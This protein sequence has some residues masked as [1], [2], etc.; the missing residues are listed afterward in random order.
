M[1]C[2]WGGGRKGDN[3][4]IEAGLSVFFFYNSFRAYLNLHR[5]ISEHL[6]LRNPIFHLVQS[7]TIIKLYTDSSPRTCEKILEYQ[8]F[9]NTQPGR[10][11]NAGNGTE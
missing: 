11:E 6:L 5:F 8:K 4:D 2:S 3:L 7:H 1:Q 10:G 9:I